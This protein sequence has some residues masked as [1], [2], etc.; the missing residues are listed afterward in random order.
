M[1][2]Y[3]AMPSAYG[4]RAPAPRSPGFFRAGPVVPMPVLLATA[5]RKG[6]S[7][8]RVGYDEVRSSSTQSSKPSRCAGGEVNRW[9]VELANLPI[10]LYLPLTGLNHPALTA[11][12]I[13][14]R[15][16]LMVC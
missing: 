1:S 8:A 16:T 5:A 11:P 13:L 4:H 7:L 6:A 14:A 10:A 2:R 15:L 9:M 3:L 12:L